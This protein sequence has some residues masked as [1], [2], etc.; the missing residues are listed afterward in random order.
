METRMVCSRMLIAFCCCQMLLGSR[1]Q[2]DIKKKYLASGPVFGKTRDREAANILDRWP[3]VMRWGKAD[4]RGAA[5]ITDKGFKNVQNVCYLISALQAI[6]HTPA[7]LSFVTSLPEP[8][9]HIEPK[10]SGTETEQERMVLL[11]QDVKTIY[12]RVEAPLSG[13][14]IRAIQRRLIS[15]GMQVDVEDSQEDAGA[16]FSLILSA[17]AGNR[18]PPGFARHRFSS[19][20]EQCIGTSNGSFMVRE[21]VGETPTD[22]HNVWYA[23][24]DGRCGTTKSESPTVMT[25]NLAEAEGDSDDVQIADLL[26]TRETVGGHVSTEDLD[27]MYANPSEWKRCNRQ[28]QVL[29]P[30]QVF[31]PNRP[32]NERYCRDGRSVSLSLERISVGAY[33]FAVYGYTKETTWTIPDAEVV[34][35]QLQ[36]WE[37]D[38]YGNHVRVRK[39][40][41]IPDDG[42]VEFQV[43]RSGEEHKQ[44]YR[45]SAFTVK[46]GPAGGGH[47]YTLARL[48]DGYWYEFNDEAAGPYVGDRSVP[49]FAGES[50]EF[51]LFTKVAHEEDVRAVEQKSSPQ[52]ILDRWPTVKTWE[53][54]DRR[55]AAFISNK[56]FLNSGAAS[57][58]ISSL[59]VVLHSETL[60]SFVTDMPEIDDGD[61]SDED[62]EPSVESAHEKPRSEV[63]SMNLLMQDVKTI[64]EQ[65]P[66]PF[67]A[68]VILQIEHALS[69]LGVQTASASVLSD[70]LTTAAGSRIPPGFVRRQSHKEADQCLSA[71]TSKSVVRAISGGDRDSYNTWYDLGN[72]RCGTTETGTPTMLTLSLA[73]AADD[74]DVVELTNLLSSRESIGGSVTSED[75]D[76]L[77][78]HPSEW[79]RCDQ[80]AKFFGAREASFDPQQPMAARYCRDGRS[81]SLRTLERVAVGTQRLAVYG[82]TQE[83]SWLIGNE[84]VLPIHLLRWKNGTDGN[85]I[86]I[87][88]RLSIPDDGM[89]VFPIQRDGERVM[90]RYR[91]MAFAAREG[92]ADSGQWFTVVRLSDG[93]WYEFNDASAGLYKR[94]VSVASLAGSDSE[95]LLFQ[96]V[97]E[98]EPVPDVHN[99]AFKLRIASLLPALVLLGTLGLP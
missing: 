61:L 51:L 63:K 40:L 8:T 37:Y 90:Q 58:L 52:T 71:S 14:I 28:L 57:Y 79:K 48:P 89:V 94:S 65:V 10:E 33:N 72:G 42:I 39:R 87:E 9:S 82:F 13:S 30:E 69:E 98:A 17:A 99:H 81:A 24:T 20:A 78:A 56:G 41:I 47:W 31:N 45:L 21:I 11:M 36:R 70:I 12:E 73:D 46:E 80:A 38:M 18:T 84:K 55:Y 91:L 86:R 3:M 59:Q 50:A 43:D 49:V 4:K 53:R 34:P 97:R 77:Y 85:L 26:S 95:F 1:I 66:A 75:L 96:K 62:E 64:Y 22:D 60:L 19:V 54:D 27:D 83:A 67:D 32:L 29:E 76:D 23:L 6:L 15:L 16:A 7:L 44:L 35:I 92:S 74:S 2:S 25:L 5:R 88:K 93:Q 68:G